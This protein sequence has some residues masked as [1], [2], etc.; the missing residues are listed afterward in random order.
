MAAGTPGGRRHLADRRNLQALLADRVGSE[1]LTEEQRVA[2]DITGL[3]VVRQ[4]MRGVGVPVRTEQF[5]RDFLQEAVNE[6]PAELARA[7]VPMEDSQASFQILRLSATSRLSHLLRTVPPS[8]TC[9]AA[10]NYD[11]LVEWALA[12]II[13]GDGAAAA[14]L[15]TPEKVAHDPTVCHNQTYLGHDALRQAHLSIQGGGLGITSSSS[16]KGRHISAASPWSWGVSSL[17]PPGG[18]FRPFL[19]D[20]LSESWR[21][22]SL[23]S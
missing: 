6:E 15:P 1:Q 17:P 22:R 18:T 11:P 21:Q 2:T 12:S 5:Q 3:T 7:L 16:I 20:C 10:A 14:G 8:I 13:V 23:K 4:G 19:N 9:Q